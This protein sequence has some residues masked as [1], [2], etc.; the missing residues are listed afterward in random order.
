MVE[1]LAADWNHWPDGLSPAAIAEAAA[2]SGFDGLE[3]GVYDTAVELADARLAEWQRL[4]DQNGV[5]VRMLL[6]SMPPERWQHGGLT[7]ES[8]R[9]RLY[10]QLENVLELAS[11]LGLD[12]IGLWPGADLPGADRRAFAA[13]T[14]Q[15]SALAHRAGMRIAIE[16]K[17]GTLVA[18]AD[19][20]QSAANEAVH[21]D[22]VGVLLDTG[23]EHAAGRDPA[24]IVADLGSRLLH[25]HLGDSDGD[26]DADLPPGRLHPLDPV[27]AA[28]DLIAYAGA[29]TPDAYG[30]VASGAMTGAD[31]LTETMRAVAAAR[32]R[33]PGRAARPGDGG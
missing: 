24:A 21:R 25:V 26:P 4:G 23:H 13:A 16:P 32:G 22:A 3:L 1:L 29:M 17:P 27:L 7:D 2:G 19:D 20:A 31:V 11:R 8:A 6:Y 33:S 28:L 12:T 30:V 15:L 18:G 10:E 9:S 14:S 5:P